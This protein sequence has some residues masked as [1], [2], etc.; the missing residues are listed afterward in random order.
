[1]KF[2]IVSDSSLDLPEETVQKM[3]I[4]VVPFYVSFD[5]SQYFREGKDIKIQEFYRH[6]VEHPDIFPKTSMPS[7]ND[8][9]DVM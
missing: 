7:Y 8:Y 4:E 1:M 5:G 6:M 9:R 3:G 2:Q